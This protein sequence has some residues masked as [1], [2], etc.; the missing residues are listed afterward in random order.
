MK[1]AVPILVQRTV[2]QMV[3]GVYQLIQDNFDDD[4]EYDGV[5]IMKA[6]KTALQTQANEIFEQIDPEEEDEDDE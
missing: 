5:M 6:I 4:T 3:S 2:K 1:K